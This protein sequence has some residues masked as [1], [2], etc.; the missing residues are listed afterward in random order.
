MKT[1][2]ENGTDTWQDCPKGS[3]GQFSARHTRNRSNGMILRAGAASVLAVLVVIGISSFRP[4]ATD[5]PTARPV[6]A[7]SCGG[8]LEQMVA[9]FDG[10]IDEQNK[11]LVHEHLDICPAC[12]KKY[13]RRASEL[14]VELLAWDIAPGVQ[15]FARFAYLGKRPSLLFKAH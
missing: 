12:R 8:T 6:L 11:R 1:N 4:T 15:A 2:Q 3:I 13:E 7:L 14:G 9:Y 5:Q 10:S